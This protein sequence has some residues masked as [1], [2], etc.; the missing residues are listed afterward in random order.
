MTSLRQIE[1]NRR[2][3]QKS[4]GSIT[5]EGK[6]RSRRNAVRHGLTAETVIQLIENPEDY[7]AFEM[8]VTADYEPNSAVEREL[9]LQLAS[10]LWRLRRATSIEAGL[11]KLESQAETN[12][13]SQGGA[14][15]QSRIIAIFNSARPGSSKGACSEAHR[16]EASFAATEADT[17]ELALRFLRLADLD[18]GAFE[19]LG[20][21]EA[22]LWRRVRQTVFTL[23]P[24]R[25]RASHAGR[26]RTQNRSQRAARGSSDAL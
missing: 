15:E 13:A 2:N 5:G 14:S 12:E 16:D 22:A 18:N 3:A 6:Q 4:T 11:L 21:Y 24:L 9:V 20:R 1:S 23:E 26:W 25:W 19:R 10:L 8:A 17:A 7:R